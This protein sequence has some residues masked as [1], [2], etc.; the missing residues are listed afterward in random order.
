M[1]VQDVLANRDRWWIECADAMTFL[2]TLPDGCVHCVI[3]SPPYFRLRRYLPEGHPDAA[4]E[5]GLEE[6]PRE[7]VRN[8]VGLFTEVRRVLHGS[9]TVWL[10]IGDTYMDKSL[11]G[12]PWLLA[13]AMRASGWYLRAENIWERPNAMTSSV[14]DR[15]AR[16]HEH[17]FL[18]SKKSRYFYDWYAVLE[19]ANQPQGTPKLT[20]P[21]ALAGLQ[22]LGS[23]TLGSNYGRPTKNKRSVWRIPTQS[24][25]ELHYAIMPE[26]L[27]IPC[28]LAGTSSEG[29]CEVCLEPWRRIVRSDRVATRPGKQTKVADESGLFDAHVIGNRD[30]ERHITMYAHQGWAAGCKCD[31]GKVPALVLDPFVGSGTVPLV[32]A[33]YG[34]RATGSELNSEYVELA[35][36]RLEKDL[37]G[38]LF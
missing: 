36:S 25:K 35:N 17:V 15:P 27:V 11:V 18:F 34:R 2:R 10:N 12:I 21:L 13:L 37:A 5:M 6:T 26:K 30:P 1:S 19:E 38:T 28:L 7:Y 29:V 23:S 32:A 4:K 14:K 3:T 8:M 24:S 31:M 33:R 9:G 20:G 16:S 22:R